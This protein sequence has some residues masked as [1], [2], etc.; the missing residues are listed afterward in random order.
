MQTP[1]HNVMCSFHFKILGK[2]A[3]WVRRI[4]N[5]VG[6]GFRMHVFVISVAFSVLLCWH[7]MRWWLKLVAL[8]C[9]LELQHLRVTFSE[10]KTHLYLTN[11]AWATLLHTR[12][13]PNHVVCMLFVFFVVDPCYVMIVFCFFVV[14]GTMGE[15]VYLGI[16]AETHNYCKGCL[17]NPACFAKSV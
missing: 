16:Q 1:I 2:P 7:R 9:T 8:S 6:L 3:P 4:L 11:M 10:H 15:H 17:G 14:G 12:K 5:Y 13:V